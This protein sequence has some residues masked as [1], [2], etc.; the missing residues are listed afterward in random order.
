MATQPREPARL[1][2]EAQIYAS[3]PLPLGSSD[4][5]RL[6]RILDNTFEDHNAPISCELIMASMSD[7]Y[8]A[9]SYM[10]GDVEA[11]GTI[12]LNGEPF[13]VRRN[14]WDFLHQRRKDQRQSEIRKVPNEHHRPGAAASCL[15]IDALCIEQASTLER[16][17]QVAMMGQ[18]YSKATSVVAW[19][20]SEN[21]DLRLLDEIS[22]FASNPFLLGFKIG[23]PVG[24][25]R[26]RWYHECNLF[27]GHPYWKRAWILQECVLAYEL[28]AQCG[29]WLFSAAILLQYA[30]ACR[31]PRMFFKAKSVLAFREQ[32]HDTSARK[33]LFP[34]SLELS[35]GCSDPRDRIFSAVA[36]MEPTLNIVPDYNKT[37]EDL[38]IEIA[39]QH[40]Q[41][42]IERSI[43]LR[44]LALR[45][46]VAKAPYPPLVYEG[47]SPAVSLRLLEAKFFQKSIRERPGLSKREFLA[48][49]LKQ[50]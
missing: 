14:L 16:N 26:K 30:L 23:C 32:W 29:S 17:H 10:W 12:I 50:A 5:I 18:I 2:S 42:D 11:T 36:I 41:W 27:F 20:G 47:M 24:M 43:H 13:K 19:L 4:S 31:L 46:R 34:W 22:H 38:F 7:S 9:L 45:L 49:Q 40:I 39:D 33:H 15:W 44:R 1:S 37:A 48:E 35:T 6:L 28:Q 3:V 25:T 8:V 21:G